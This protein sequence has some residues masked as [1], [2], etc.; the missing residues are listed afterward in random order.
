MLMRAFE[1]D[2]ISKKGRAGIHSNPLYQQNKISP[3]N[4]KGKRDVEQF[5]TASCFHDMKHFQN[6]WWVYLLQNQ[7]D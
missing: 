5:H 2:L 6:L 1:W 7:R 3:L 4:S